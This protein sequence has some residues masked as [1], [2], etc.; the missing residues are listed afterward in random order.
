MM[1]KTKIR[2]AR[3]NRRETQPKE[4]ER[5]KGPLQ[6]QICHEAK[7]YDDWETVC[8]KRHK[9]KFTR[10]MVK[11]GR[12]TNIGTQHRES[13]DQG[14]T[15]INHLLERRSKHALK[16]V[17]SEM[18]YF[19]NFLLFTI[20]VVS[21]WNTPKEAS[22]FIILGMTDNEQDQLMPCTITGMKK[23][24][25]VDHFKSIFLYECVVGSIP[26]F[27][28]TEVLV[29][30]DIVGVIEIFS[31]RASQSP[32]V[33]NCKRQ[34]YA[35][36]THEGDMWIQ[37]DA[38][39]VVCKPT[40]D[41]FAEVYGW[42][43]NDNTE[44]T[45]HT[46]DSERD[47]C[48][49]KGAEDNNRMFISF[50]QQQNTISKK[51]SSELKVCTSVD[52]MLDAVDNF[53][54]GHFILLAGDVPSISTNMEAIT[55]I[56]WLAVFDFDPY[57]RDR[58]L[59]CSN[60]EILA[61]MTSLH[62]TT[63]K[64]IDKPVSEYE[65]NR[66][67]I[68]G[69]RDDPE[70]RQCGEESD[71]LRSWSRKIKR[72]VD[73]YLSD[74]QDFIADYTVLTSIVLWPNDER[75]LPYILKMI[76]KLDEN[77]DPP[78]KLV[79]VLES[80]PRTEAAKTCFRTLCDEQNEN[81]TLVRM[82]LSDVLN[83]LSHKLK[84]CNNI[85]ATTFDLPASDQRNVCILDRDASWL[86]EHLN[87]LFQSC[88]FLHE[89]NDIEFLQE[90]SDNFYRG[91]TLHWRTWYSCGVGHFDIERDIYKNAKSV[92]E[93]NIQKNKSGMVTLCHAPGAGGTTLAQRLAWE[94]HE[95]VP[96]V[97]VRSSSIN[98][99]EIVSRI[100]FLY[101]KT[102][103]PVLLL[104]DGED[105]QKV[106]H[107]LQY[108]K[109]S[110]IAIILHVKRC[111]CK[112]EMKK[113]DIDILWLNGI[114]SSKEAKQL[115]LKLKAHC[116]ND[117]GKKRILVTL[118]KE[119]EQG[120]RHHLINFGLTVFLHEFKGISSF[121][122]GYF[123][124][125]EHDTF[126]TTDQGILLYL[127]LAYF[128]GHTSLPCQFFN[129]L[130]H[131]PANYCVDLDDFPQSVQSF[132]VE[133]E[134]D[135]RRS[136]IRICHTLVAKEILD[137]ILSR[138]RNSKDA[139]H[140]GLSEPARHR[141]ASLCLEFI[142]YASRREGRG[143]SSSVTVGN[144]LRKIFIVRDTMDMYQG[145]EHLIRKSPISN[146]LM[147]INS[148]PPMFCQRLEVLKKLVEVFPKD[149]NFLAHL[150][151]FY[152]NCLPQKEKEAEKCFIMSLELCEAHTKGTYKTDGKPSDRMKLPLMYIY[153]MYGMFLLKRIKRE[154]GN[155][156]FEEVR[157]TSESTKSPCN[158]Y[159]ILALVKQ[160]C[161][162]FEKSRMYTPVGHES[163]YGYTGEIEVRLHF[164]DFL[165]K[166]ETVSY[167]NDTLGICKNLREMADV[168]VRKSIPVIDQLI[169]E[170]TKESIGQKEI[171]HFLTKYS[172]WYDH[173]FKGNVV[174]L[175]RMDECHD[176]DS[177]RL[178]IAMAKIN[179]R[180]G[181]RSSCNII[182]N[183]KEKKHIDAIVILYEKVFEMLDVCD[184]YREKKTL[185][186]NLV[187]WLR[188]I[189]HK[190]MITEYRVD[191]VLVQV[192]KI[193]NLISSPVVTFY[194]FVLKSLLGFG[195]CSESRQVDTSALYDAKQLKLELNA[196][197]RYVMKPK[198]PREWVGD[199]QNGIKCLLPGSQCITE[200]KTNRH[201]PL[202]HIFKG[203]V[204]HPN[205]KKATGY[206]NLDLGENTCPVEVFFIPDIANLAGSQ[207]AGRRVEFTLAFTIKNGYEAFHVTSLR[208]YKC[209]NYPCGSSVEITSAEEFAVCC[210]C[211]RPVYRNDFHEEE[212]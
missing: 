62:I 185:E 39:A 48:S 176:I 203:S 147:D 125:S 117:D 180:A 165:Q 115:T 106:F 178:R 195:I 154:T 168:F 179:S 174:A 150:G 89:E 126:P 86:R 193:N 149:P 76:A 113:E 97:H 161:S 182:D 135:G 25:T 105:D 43:A 56:P 81:L 201:F 130:L 58:G 95:K 72:L 6:G 84:L 36:A 121:V 11:P 151:R 21:M 42:F 13:E 209:T 158:I 111:L 101:S 73:P 131:L 46:T 68:R 93:K 77:I 142:S 94:F 183:I 140:V 24:H 200:Y 177:C 35:I 181:P 145:S 120:K 119:T 47:N 52:Q 16:F 20:D 171:C 26:Q 7:D 133:D 196:S 208:K 45:H 128:Y 191:Q 204:C 110:C 206:I 55:S 99:L 156:T 8:N 41:R 118:C 79:I 87:V 49:A 146:I 116:K 189:R 12:S 139:K 190:E 152:A 103:K 205:K 122:K 170:C 159:D 141:L 132:V 31:C 27:S 32:C 109:S 91:G 107:L 17:P 124:V 67:F 3:L 167:L 157:S 57:S 192:V 74:I 148:P 5:R 134:G 155:G 144:Y 71:D 83:G 153:H 65:T 100:E 114:V 10:E 70:S 212:N 108:M 202:L 197:G 59:L 22:S 51:K 160:A 123:P 194:I 112:P 166:E 88:P 75:M 40:D 162:L 173:L 60:E 18:V 64:T 164:C 136:N 198:H 188:A 37:K 19:Q 199:S 129:E 66:C 143:P 53:R 29:G 104:I 211:G 90:E 50:S 169:N 184:T 92:I 78:P 15:C 102:H 28:Y 175:E 187:D 138:G 4:M 1:V 54:K 34:N 210:A 163:G 33:F 186:M 14:K 80:E 61:K 38:L 30:T 44:D 69:I 96:T 9:R 85:N 207:H 98:M 137:H 2:G 23:S 63:W 127:A 172:C 82:G